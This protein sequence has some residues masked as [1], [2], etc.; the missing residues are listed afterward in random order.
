MSKSPSKPG[1][2]GTL[3]AGKARDRART[4]EHGGPKRGQ[5]RPTPEAPAP[6][7][8]RSKLVRAAM[9]VFAREGFAAASTRMI[10]AESGR[11]D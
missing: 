11:L 9:R 4:A 1:A 7:D 2:T 5:L 10:A 6:E 8:T 3:S